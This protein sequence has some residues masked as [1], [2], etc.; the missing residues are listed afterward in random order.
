MPRPLVECVPN[1]SEGRDPAVVDAIAAAIAAHPG[2]LLL[3]REMDP[4]H[5]RS[6]LT[7]AAPPGIIVEAAV[8]GVARAAQLIDLNRHQG[9]HPRLGACDV[10]PFVPLQEVTLDECVRLAEQAAEAVW[11][12]LGIPVYLYEAAARRPERVRLENIR[13]GQF[14]ALREAVLRDPDRR[15]DI[16]GPEL[17]PTAGALI[18]GARPLLIAWNVNL[19]T[20]DVAVAQRI[21]R[22]IRASSGGFPCVKALGLPLESKNLAQVSMNLTNFEVTPVHTVFEAIQ[23]EAAR[24]GVS[25]AGTEIIGLIPK[26]AIEGAAGHFLQ[27]EDFRPSMILENRVAEAS[28]G[29]SWLTEFLDSLASP[30]EPSGGGSA[31]AVAAAMAAALGAM[32]A[33]HTGLDPSVFVQDQAFFAQSAAADAVAWQ[34]V[35]EA[36]GDL[37]ALQQALRAAAEVPMQVIERAAALDRRLTALLAAAPGPLASELDTARALL[38]AASAGARATVRLNLDGITSIE[39]RQALQARLDAVPAQP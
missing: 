32:A 18:A 28:A 10:L 35:V 8:A 7:F 21:A 25:V 23:A 31:A 4:D 13:R 38:A 12:R 27:I 11:Q 14:E 1:F 33:R 3:D 26:A 16:G 6:V 20:S 37:K 19:N 9:V 34:A 24:D 15:P 36:A 5:H 22:R 17:H 39:V 30:A 29:Q 2:V